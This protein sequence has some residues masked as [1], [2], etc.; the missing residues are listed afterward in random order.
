MPPARPNTCSS[1][2]G[3]VVEAARAQQAVRQVPETRTRQTSTFSLPSTVP[4]CL[5]RIRIFQH[6]LGPTAQV[7]ENHDSE[8]QRRIE[9]PGPHES[10]VKRYGV[11][12]PRT[13]GIP[14]INLVVD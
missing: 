3:V 1:R 2:F 4:A 8:I 10:R 13:M 6:F 5:W 14:L 7:L 12:H 11:G 9:V